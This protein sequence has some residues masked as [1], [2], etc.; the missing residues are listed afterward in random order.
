VALSEER[1]EAAA[2]EAAGQQQARA[3]LPHVQG[4]HVRLTIKMPNGAVCS[5]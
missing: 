3:A 1:S 5:G 2:R 4:D